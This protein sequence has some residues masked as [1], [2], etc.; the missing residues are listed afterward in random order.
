[1]TPAPGT[2][3]EG[4]KD[5][6]GRCLGQAGAAG[7]QRHS[8]CVGRIVQEA[9][10]G[11]AREARAPAGPSPA[12]PR[13][14]WGRSVARASCSRPGGRPALACTAQKGGRWPA[15]GPG[16]G[17]RSFSFSEP[18]DK[19]EDACGF[20]CR[21]PRERESTG[22][23]CPGDRRQA[24]TGA[25]QTPVWWCEPALLT[26][27]QA[28]GSPAGELL[29][30]GFPRRCWQRSCEW[31]S[32]TEARGRVSFPWWHLANPSTYTLGVAWE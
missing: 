1:M 18:P 16:R 12:S 30:S 7:P 31:G 22:A 14:A 13:R 2:V 26:Q 4:V 9:A 24:G 3:R 32:Y 5:R 10:A 15:P 27:A 28:P 11:G 20:P 8:V 19:T 6:R 25:E 17:R 23:A 21:C 29:S